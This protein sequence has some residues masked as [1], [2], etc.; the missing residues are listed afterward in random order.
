MNNLSAV[1]LAVGVVMLEVTDTLPLPLIAPMVV[2]AMITY[3]IV[4]SEMG[5]AVMAMITTSGVP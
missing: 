4:R 2:M 5:D 1:D 3:L